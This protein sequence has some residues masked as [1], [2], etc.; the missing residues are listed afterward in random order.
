M[1]SDEQL[2]WLSPI[3]RFALDTIDARLAILSDANTE[4]LSPV[5]AA[6]QARR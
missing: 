3:E 2:G 6:K 1:A 5:D 4:A